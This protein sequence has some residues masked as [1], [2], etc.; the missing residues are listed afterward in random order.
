MKIL[1]QVN[2]FQLY[3]NPLNNLYAISDKDE[4]SIPFDVYEAEY[5]LNASDIDFI[6]ECSEHI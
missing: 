4:V 6:K 1:R 5:L 3:Q 2:E